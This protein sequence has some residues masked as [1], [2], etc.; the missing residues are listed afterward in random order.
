MPRKDTTSPWARH[1]SPWVVGVALGLLSWFAFATAD[2]GLGITTPFEQGAALAVRAAA[3]GS[4]SVASYYAAEDTPKI[5]WE[6]MLVLGV[7]V[8]GF[9]S[10]SI[11]RRAPRAP[12]APRRPNHVDGHRSVP[13]LWAARFGS[14]VPLRLGAAFVGGFILIIGARL[15]RGCTSGHGI[16]GALQLAAASW[17][18]ISAAFVVAVT[19]AFLLFSRERDHV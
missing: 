16:T 15:A 19:T 2:H 5:G 18:F 14:S 10:A 17:L 12:G 13:P 6:W 3:P 1:W 11:Q 4:S 8:G 9:A 7:F